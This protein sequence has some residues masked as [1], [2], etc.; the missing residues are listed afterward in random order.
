[1]SPWGEVE[2]CRE[3]DGEGEREEEKEEAAEEMGVGTEASHQE[4]QGKRRNERGKQ[5]SGRPKRIGTQDT[6]AGTTTKEEKT[7]ES[8][9]RNKGQNKEGEDTQTERRVKNGRAWEDL[10]SSGWTRPSQAWTHARALLG[11]TKRQGQ[12][13]RVVMVTQRGVYWEVH[14]ARTKYRED[15]VGSV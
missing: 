12:G 15:R 4:Q 7:E 11:N 13:G 6:P 5:A 14:K 9:R 1:M 8:N 10:A 3:R 2:A